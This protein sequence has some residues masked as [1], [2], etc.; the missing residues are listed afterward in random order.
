MAFTLVEKQPE[1]EAVIQRARAAGRVALDTEAASFHRYHDRVY[2]LQVTAAGETSVVDPLAV[3]AMHP[4][5]EIL[6]DGQREQIF[7]DA[8][9]ARRLIPHLFGY[10]T[11]H[12][13]ATR[14][15]AQLR[16]EPSIGL[17]ALLELYF[18]LKPDKRFQRAD[19]SSRPLTAPMLA[20]AA[21]DTDHPEELRDLLHRKLVEMNRLAQV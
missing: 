5:G 12:L 20:D 9:Y 19:W 17:G 13:F 4:L 18:G 8:D 11:R 14:I 1:F 15:A 16:G 6:G 10:S 7:H 3:E 21:G 2:L